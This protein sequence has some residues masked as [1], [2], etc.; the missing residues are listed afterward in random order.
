VAGRR[1]FRILTSSHQSGIWSKN[2]NTHKVQQIHT[3]WQVYTQGTYY[4]A[5]KTTNNNIHKTFAVLYFDLWFVSLSISHCRVF[6]IISNKAEFAKKNTECVSWYLT[7]LAWNISY[8]EKKWRDIMKNEWMPFLKYPT[9][10]PD[11]KELSIT[12]QCLRNFP[13]FNSMSF[14]WVQ[15]ELLQADRQIWRSIY[16]KFIILRTR[17]N[18]V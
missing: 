3:R 8:F 17:L 2:S 7:K 16:S 14:L 12:A 4:N 1:T 18:C 11:S 13:I 5:H 6:Y 10:L 15:S 9:C